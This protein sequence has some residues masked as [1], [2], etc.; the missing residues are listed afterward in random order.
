MQDLETRERIGRSQDDG[1]ESDDSPRGCD[2]TKSKGPQY[3]KQRDSSTNVAQD[4]LPHYHQCTR[5][6]EQRM[7]LLEER[8]NVY[9]T[10]SKKMKDKNT[11][12]PEPAPSPQPPQRTIIPKL[13]FKFWDEFTNDEPGSRT[14]MIDVLVGEA[15]ELRNKALDSYTG[16]QGF[17]KAVDHLSTAA[18]EPA[19]LNAGDT[20]DLQLEIKRTSRAQTARTYSIQYMCHVACFPHE[21]VWAADRIDN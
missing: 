7:I 14:H 15:E 21:L 12:E 9:E 1:G 4:Q 2:A 6:L 16:S 8:W 11:A 5:D 18:R 13:A 10:E 20:C 19:A 17:L 3:S